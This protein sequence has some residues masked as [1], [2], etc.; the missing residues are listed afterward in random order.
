MTL[1]KTQRAKNVN[2]AAF[3]AEDMEFSYPSL[4]SGAILQTEY[5]STLVLNVALMDNTQMYLQCLSIQF[6]SETRMRFRL[7]LSSM[8]V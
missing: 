2:V 3:G 4:I 7:L 8:S 1:R 5:T 6:L